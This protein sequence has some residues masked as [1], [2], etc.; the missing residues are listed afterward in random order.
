LLEELDESDPV[1]E[2]T[3]NKLNNLVKNSHLWYN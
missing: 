1:Y 3:L 2:D